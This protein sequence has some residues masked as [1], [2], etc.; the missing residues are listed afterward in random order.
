M[1][2]RLAGA[3]ARG[4][5]HDAAD[6]APRRARASPTRQKGRAEPQAGG[7]DRPRRGPQHLADRH[8][9][10]IPDTSRRTSPPARP[11]MIYANV[12]PAPI[13][14]SRRGR[15]TARGAFARWPSGR[16]RR[17]AGPRPRRTRA[18]AP[19]VA[20]RPEVGAVS[21][22]T[23]GLIAKDAARPAE[24]RRLVVRRH[25]GECR[26]AGSRRR[27]TTRTSR[28]T[29]RA[30]RPSARGDRRSRAK[31]NFAR[32]FFFRERRCRGRAAGGARQ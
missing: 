5:R 28:R 8:P 32:F 2:A 29:W 6:G 18:W 19:V 9:D 10:W 17:P 12:D 4:P 23:S 13:A 16:T 15:R 27:T 24:R 31:N 21:T 14:P 20:S 30:A 11:A 7:G 26:R 1:P 3:G 25:V 22:V